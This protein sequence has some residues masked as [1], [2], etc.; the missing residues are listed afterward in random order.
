MSL[1]ETALAFFYCVLHFFLQ[2]F[3]PV[4][5]GVGDGVQTDRPVPQ[6]ETAKVD[7]FDLVQ[8][9]VERGNL[10]DVVADDVQQAASDVRLTAWRHACQYFG[11]CRE[12]RTRCL[13]NMPSKR[14][15]ELHWTFVHVPTCCKIT[16]YED[17]IFKQ[18]ERFG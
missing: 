16:G 17:I 8:E 7:A 4:V 1:R 15:K 5:D 6:E 10:A 9:C 2:T 11:S 3:A 12:A 14:N 13:M 18:L